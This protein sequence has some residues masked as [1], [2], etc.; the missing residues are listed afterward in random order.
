M[1]F[2][3]HP[4]SG[5]GIHNKELKEL[6]VKELMHL[7][8]SKDLYNSAWLQILPSALFGFYVLPSHNSVEHYWFLTEL[9]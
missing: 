9:I 6:M 4:I 1:C 5:I 7:F 2:G 8:G 3:I